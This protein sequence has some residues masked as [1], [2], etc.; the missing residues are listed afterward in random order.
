MEKENSTLVFSELENIDTICAVCGL[1]FP[2]SANEF[3]KSSLLLAHLMASVRNLVLNMV[4]VNKELLTL[5]R[6]LVTIMV[7]NYEQQR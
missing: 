7:C 6:S 4:E 2:E 3:Q 5:I 1:S